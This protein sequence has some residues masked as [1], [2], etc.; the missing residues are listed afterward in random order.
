MGTRKP[1]LARWELRHHEAAAGCRP[2]DAFAARPG[3]VKAAIGAALAAR[4]LAVARVGGRAH[5]FRAAD[6]GHAPLIEALAHAANGREPAAA[7][8]LHD[9][10]TTPDLADAAVTFRTSCALAPA[11]TAPSLAL[12][13]LKRLHGFAFGEHFFGRLTYKA[14]EVIA[15]AV[16]RASGALMGEWPRPDDLRPS[17]KRSALL[18]LLACVPDTR[19]WPDPV[20][21]LA[22][23]GGRTSRVPSGL[24]K[25]A[26]QAP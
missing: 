14:L 17:R 9:H 11:D 4:G 16:V 5:V 18:A 26:T 23:Q 7:N 10:L 1:R 19:R 22:R 8:A 15:K 3:N 13:D 24:A 2:G 25:L 12:S 21:E 6:V 20:A